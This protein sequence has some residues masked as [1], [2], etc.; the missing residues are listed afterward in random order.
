MR[1]ESIQYIL[2]TLKLL[3]IFLIVFKKSQ[4]KIDSAK[5][6][7]F[8][9]KLDQR[10]RLTVL[11]LFQR[12][13]DDEKMVNFAQEVLDLNSILKGKNIKKDKKLNQFSGDDY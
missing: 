3:L 5:L 7:S 1:Q 10:L 12:I 2:N 9:F 4:K 6:D 13:A 11:V 8:L